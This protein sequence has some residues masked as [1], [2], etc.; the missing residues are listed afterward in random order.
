MMKGIY[1]CKC[2][3]SLSSSIP[4]RHGSYE[5]L[6]ADPTVDVIWIGTPD[7][8]HGEHAKLALNAGKPVLVEKPFC[9]NPSEAAEVYELSKKKQLFCMEGMWTRFVPSMMHTL[10]LITAGTIGAVKLVQSDF[11]CKFPIPAGALNALGVYNLALHHMVYDQHTP[12]QKMAIPS[13]L[14]AS[15]TLRSDGMTDDQV[16]GVLQFGDSQLSTFAASLLVNSPNE[17]II[18]G[19]KGRIRLLGP[20]WHS[21]NK[22]IVEVEGEKPKEVGF[23]GFEDVKFIR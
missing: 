6:V 7:A 21:T 23:E 13:E 18:V 1:E 19:E 8:C 2:R 5:S 10:N 11:G 9:A 4:N 17:A 22:I 15:G 12:N 20:L 14:Y 16:G 3:S